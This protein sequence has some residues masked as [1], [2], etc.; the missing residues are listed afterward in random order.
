MGG[1][2]LGATFSKNLPIT[3]IDKCSIF[4]WWLQYLRKSEKEN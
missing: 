3:P 1:M 4:E 2:N